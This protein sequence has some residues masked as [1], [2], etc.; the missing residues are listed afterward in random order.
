MRAAWIGLGTCL[1]SFVVLGGDGVAQS[2]WL[3]V[4]GDSSGDDFGY[5]IAG[6][7]DLDGDGWPDFVA[8]APY[9]DDAASDGGAIRVHS[10]RTGAVLWSLAGLQTF[11]HLGSDV[12]FVGDLDGDLGDEIA[13][14]VPGGDRVEIRSG[15]TGALVFQ[16]FGDA[17]HSLGHCVSAAGDVDADGTP[18]VA[19]GSPDGLGSVS[20]SGSV[21]IRSG[22]LGQSLLT[23]PGGAFGDEFGWSI[24][25][26]GD[27]DLDG[28]DDIAIGAQTEAATGAVTWSSGSDGHTLRK[29]YG[30]TPNERFGFDVANAG[31]LD[32]DG[33]DETW[34]GAPLATSLTGVPA[35][36]V[37]RAFTGASGAVLFRFDGANVAGN[38]GRC[39]ASAGDLDGDGVADCII[40]EPSAPGVL[41]GSSV[42]RCHLLSGASG[43]KLGLLVGNHAYQ[44]LGGAVAGAGDVNGDGRSEFLL[45]S[46]ATAIPGAG[47][48]AVT[49]GSLAVLPRVGNLFTFGTGCG[50]DSGHVPHLQFSGRPTL[51]SPMA[52]SLTNA[53][54][55]GPGL[56]VIGNQVVSL[57]ITASCA[58]L[59]AP[60]LTFAIPVV[61]GLQPTNGCLGIPFVVPAGWVGTLRAQAIVVDPLSTSGLAASNGAAVTIG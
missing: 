16:W 18:D 6:G 38:F 32:G 27:L 59:V 46:E 12:A 5:A 29:R 54:A 43:M 61:P 9:D 40:G 52:L 15:R 44:S 35:T 19:L 30:V 24:A 60:T 51:G 25:P 33:L 53:S 41:G 47:D 42:G 39:V 17:A 49:I 10:G 13:I 21:E 28:V 56:L 22:A 14:G 1:A 4:R 34:V 23:I 48:G 45:Q 55:G 37:V 58:L 3:R 20:G 7:R 11:E 50:S 57:P 26:C 2:E 31:D 8:S 36:G